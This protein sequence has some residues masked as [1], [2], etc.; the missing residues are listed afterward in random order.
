MNKQLKADWIAA[1]RSGEYKQ[2]QNKM[3]DDGY[4]CCLA[5]L[6][7]VAGVEYP[8]DAFDLDHKALRGF[9]DECSLGD[10]TDGIQAQLISLNDD[11]EYGFSKIADWIEVNVEAA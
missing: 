11:K 8:S 9:R 7:R 10:N 1:L 3:E 5:V 2:G 4:L 6:C